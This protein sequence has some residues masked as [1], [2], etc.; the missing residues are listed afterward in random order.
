MLNWTASGFLLLLLWLLP[1]E[2]THPTPADDHQ[3]LSSLTCD[4][5]VD[6]GPDTNVCA[7]GGLVQL[8][9]SI[10]G[11]AIFYE[12]TPPDGLSN[13]FILNPVADVSGP[14]TYTLTA[15]GVDPDN[16]N[17]ITNGDFSLGNVGFSTDYNYVID[18]PGLQNEM[19]PEAT[20]AIIPNPNL[21]HTGFA[22][23]PD[24]TGGGDMMVVNGAASHQNVWCQTI[25]VNP[26]A[27]Y[28]VAAWVAS[29]NSASPAE[30][31]FSINGT[32]IGQIVYA[33]STPCEWTPFNATWDS[34]NNTM[35]EICILNLNTALG[36]NDF[37]IDDISMVALCAVED[38]VEITIYNEVAPEP[39]IDGPAFLCEGEIGTYTATFPPDPP[40]YSYQWTIPSGASVI[41]GQGTPV[42]TIQWEDV[43]V[44]ELCLE[45]ETRC[46]MNEACFEVTVG[47]FPLF[48]LISGPTSLC[49]G[50]IA[51]F[52]T[53]EYDPD[54]T[55]HWTIPPNLTIISGQGTNEIE[56]EWTAPGEVEVC[57]EVTNVCGTSDNCSILS[58]WP[59]YLTLFDTTLCEG[60]AIDIN[61]T[62]YGNGLYSGTEIFTSI[63]GCDSIVE[64]DITEA[65][66]L[67]LMITSN[68]CPGDSIFL[69]GEYQTQEGI[70]TDTFST[71]IG[72]D[73]IVITNLVITAFDTTWINSFS[74]LPS[75]TGVTII[76]YTQGFCDST[77]VTT[78]MLSPT[79]TTDL[80]LYSCFSAD[81]GSI[82]LLLMNQ[83]GCDSLVRTMT[84][85]L[86]TDSVHFFDTT[87]DPAQ[88]GETT[89]I[90]TNTSGCDSVVITTVA[91]VLSDTTIINQHT[92][93]YADTGT[94]STLLIN[95]MGC[96]S[97]I[98]LNTIYGGSDTTFLNA[99]SCNPIDSGYTY[100][101]LVNQFACDSVISL[102]TTLLASDSTFLLATSCFP[103]DTGIVVEVLTNSDGCDSTVI[104]TTTLNPIDECTIEAFIV[105]QQ[106]LC[107]GDMGYINITTTIGLAPYTISWKHED[108]IL[109]GSLTI[110]STPGSSV[111]EQTQPGTYYFEISSANGLTQFD[112]VSITSI[113]PLVVSITV[114]VDGN[115]FGVAC[116]GDSTGMA[117]ST[118]E[119][120]G[121]PP[122][123]Y[124][125]SE[126]S[127]S[128][129]LD[130]LGA[131][132]YALTVTDDH[133]CTTS[134]EVIII[135][136]AQMSFVLD[137][138]NITCFGFQNGSATMANIGGGVSPWLTSLNGNT[139]SGALTYSSLGAGNHHLSVMDQNGCIL[140]ENFLIEE[141]EAWSINLGMDTSVVF[142]N[143]IDLEINIIGTPTGMVQASWSDG[144]CSNCLSRNVS[145][146]STT[147][148]GVTATDQN[149]CTD[150]DMI[151]IKI[152]IDRNL[153][154]PNVFSP[155]GDQIN[156]L[157][158]LHAGAGLEEIETMSI[159]D[160]WGNL[161]FQTAHF[162]PEDISKAWDGTMRGEALNPGVYIYTLTAVYKDG[163]KEMKNG[164]VTLLR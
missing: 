102:Y 77:V 142:G 137:T 153:Y 96:D 63:A 33:P 17:L 70:Y 157:F 149:G 45:I 55:Y 125:W 118:F 21:V 152:V 84:L 89:Q 27:F 88:V 155:N 9:G 7:P 47:T 139:F 75:D 25:N 136:P 22:A 20:Y 15:F 65:P 123:N 132:V 163:K 48:P 131:G 160:R 99:T 4:L 97:L 81:T 79:D 61:G 41:S 32:P 121:T 122:Y 51:V 114:P 43:Q 52:Y 26:N 87:C 36:G 46:D 2:S 8:M 135:E 115:G 127:T 90:F 37:A 98:I 106:P 112:T 11:T 147:T 104:T 16:P 158:T 109:N 58:L 34:G 148:Y 80:L 19:V 116:F 141:P 134:A 59:E 23:C 83:F 119:E 18:I 57:V 126:Q 31:Q 40:I 95:S 150:V 50:E 108:M 10:T 56:V 49:P 103:Q 164:D 93:T 144:Q 100:L 74:C 35:A 3:V 101:T 130:M 53:A 86:P 105:V 117:I 5:I 24:H 110:N 13:P 92:C 76:T 140:E 159:F 30:L 38:E 129:Q 138:T 120:I 67:E 107:F 1:P 128:P 69:E 68:L 72:C 73:S 82:S 143:S 91:F 111:V 62:I 66:T 162:H 151:T 161:V 124:L 60:S 156:D 12:W 29:V 113:P 28:N 54:D 78:V 146:G 14:I 94:V 42:I 64:I 133:G 154:I 145:P 6:A 71:I 39:I 85:L 44:G